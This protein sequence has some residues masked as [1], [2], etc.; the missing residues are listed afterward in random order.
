MGDVTDAPHRAAAT[1]L[2]QLI[3]TYLDSRDLVMMGGHTPGQDPVLDQAI[4]L[5]PQIRAL[6]AQDQD[7][8]ATL[9]DSRAALLDL[10]GADTTGARL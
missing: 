10:L 4:A 1:R 6:I 7:S 2:R 9:A 8:R 5:W 3:A